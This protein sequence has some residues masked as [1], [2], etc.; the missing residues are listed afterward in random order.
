MRTNRVVNLKFN[1]MKHDFLKISSKRMLCSALIA[2]AICTGGALPVW[3]DAAEV[4][5]TAQA[6]TVK[7]VI[8]D[9]DGI[10]VIGASVL[11]KGTTNG[12]I[13]D[14]DGN[15]SLSVS[16]K[17]AVIVISYIGYKT[18]E[19]KASDPKLANLTLQEDS[20]MLEEVVV[21]G[22]GVQKKETLTGAVTVV[23]DKMLKGKGSL[24]S[25]LQA[26]QGQVP[27]VTITRTS[28]APGDESW[29]M[30]LRGA[31]S[32][33]TADPLIV[34]DGVAYEG[35][36]A[37]RN[38]NPSDIES[39]NFLKDAS[40][41]IYGSR[42]A[43][44]VVLITTKQAKEG[45]TRVEYNASYTA[46][47][48]G[49]Q[50]ELMSLKE[51]ANA[52]IQARTNDGYTDSD[53][54]MRF[55]KLALQ[56][57]GRYIDLLKNPANPISEFDD[58]YDYVFMDTDW[59]D[60]LF[61][62]A[63]S[64]QHDLSISGGTEKNLY[65]LSLGYMYDGSNLKW[66]NNNNQRFN[67]RLTNKFQIT[68]WFKLESV[69][70]YNRQ[71]QVA[72]SQITSTLTG[73]Y[74]QPGLPA[75]TIDGKPYS[76]GT[77]L[78]PIWYAEL[79]GDNRLRV[80]EVNISEKLTF[81]LMKGLDLVGNVGYNTSNA[82]RDNKQM[83]ITS[84]N[85]AGTQ[86]NTQ[87]TVSRQSES[88]Y[89][90]TSSRR[91]F[92]S[93]SGYLN[94]AKDFETG[95]SLNVMAGAQ[96]ELTEYDY[97]GAKAEDI[98]NSLETIN[99]AGQVSLTNNNGT[100]WHE[101]IMSYYSRVNY[102]YMSKYLAELNFRYDGSSKFKEGRW[103]PFWGISLGWR[104]SEEG[105]MDWAD[106]WLDEFK[107]RASYGVVG[108]QSGIDRYEG[109]QIYNFR[110]LNGALLGDN[111]AATI[112]TNGR[113]AS[114][115]REWERIHNYN[116]GLDF[117]FLHGRLTGTL[118]GYWKKNN[119]MLIEVTYPGILG[120]NAG[121][122]NAGKFEAKGFEI[123]TNWS[124]R[125]GEVGYHVGGTFSYNTNEL[126]DI[127]GVTVLSSGFVGK[128]QGYAL[129][130]IF[131]LRYIGK[132][133]NEEQRQKYLYRY[134][135]GNT[136]GLTND[137][138]VGDNMYEDVNKD[139]KLDYNDYVYLGTD[140]PKI[141]FSFN[142]GIE[143]NNFDLSVIFQGVAQRTIFRTGENDGNAN[144]RIPMR[145]PYYN[146]T[147]QSVGNTWSP[148]NPDARYPTYTNNSTINDYNYQCSS[149]SVENGAYIRLKN[150][151]LGYTFP[152]TLL[153]KTK[154]ISAARVY[155]TGADLWEFSK[156]NDGWDPEASRNV[157]G[158]GRYPFVRTVT[159]GLNLTF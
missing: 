139:G 70:A 19:L 13:T 135:T 57:E 37:L 66:G 151:T 40:A 43:G 117:G 84:Y 112:D 158:T 17:D 59:T 60:V 71:D 159:F 109:A 126:T 7:G 105:F 95:H 25:P 1:L 69:I 86:V 143:W 145:Q 52:V 54:W 22:Y 33:N 101:A 89:E 45:K 27:G 48:V 108:N 122:S 79:G 118:E 102:N 140:D 55:A 9:A 29:G 100:K 85:Y 146:T 152:E 141:S 142:G 14:I 78:S 24:S 154:V 128:Q 4:H 32:A 137:I 88:S 44:G 133:Q 51:W 131:G 21:V 114:Y 113:I 31:V 82:N 80:S 53:Q 65:R 47:F 138:R 96:Y 156:I 3:A 42:A 72:P 116:I 103:S 111:R 144:Y 63:G 50:P 12:V 64:T 62:N 136:I 110:A 92:Y 155:V 120:D 121:Y 93:F 107:I 134:L 94:Y 34:I 49:L 124:D 119:N 129:N 99:G 11:E 67:L 15:Y 23:T 28:S 153:A 127:G 123:Q 104:L 149:W 61:G 130:S 74:P 150:V 157:R 38:I 2:S 125:I 18:V 35:T 97:F 81:N 6:V 98:Q 147:N 26:M 36:N 41:A 16:S 76:W 46:K 115:S 90:K 58:V 77:W 68:D 10:P 5:T 148:E 30:K 8:L 39:I 83:A 73:S 91:D 20:E 75:S 56:Y 132:I 87:P 106:D